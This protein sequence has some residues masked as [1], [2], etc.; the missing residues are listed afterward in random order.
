MDSKVRRL[1]IKIETFTKIL[2]NIKDLSNSSTTKV[3]CIA[4]RKDFSKIA[5]FGYNGSYSGAEQNTETG[6]EEDSLI[7]GESGF[8]HAEVNMI[9]KFKE[10]DPENYIVLL[11][12][13]PCKMCTKILVNAG[14]KHVYWIDNYR[15]LEHLEIFN[16]CKITHGQ[17]NNLVDDYHLIKD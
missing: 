8:I 5:S 3:G 13:S 16:Q 17:I 12:L 7:P 9:A 1:Q 2:K 15:S 6:T 11:T 10:Y 4:L 14:F